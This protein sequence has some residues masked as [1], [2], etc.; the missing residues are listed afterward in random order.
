MVY[1]VTVPVVIE[2]CPDVLG[3]A[4]PNTFGPDVQLFFGIIVPIPLA[5]AVEADVNIIRCPNQFVGQFRT[6]ACAKNS[7]GFAEGGENPLIPPA[8]VA[9]FHDIAPFMVK[10]T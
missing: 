3:S 6:A 2:I 1:R 5:R 4:F 10:L 8:Y 7:P 9:E